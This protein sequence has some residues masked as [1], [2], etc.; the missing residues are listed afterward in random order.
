MIEYLLER[1]TPA[2][3]EE[4]IARV[5]ELLSATWVI[6]GKLVAHLVVDG[7]WMHFRTACGRRGVNALRASADDRV[8]EVCLAAIGTRIGTRGRP[9]GPS[10]T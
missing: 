5:A 4:R 3:L 6:D 8:C 2:E 10:R 9:E 7:S 1:N